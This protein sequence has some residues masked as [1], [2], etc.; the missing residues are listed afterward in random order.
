MHIE[1]LCVP[2]AVW[3]LRVLSW[4]SRSMAMSDMAMLNNY[5]DS[6]LVMIQFDF[7]PCFLGV[8]NGLRELEAEA[9]SAL[10]RA[11]LARAP[12]LFD[13]RRSSASEQR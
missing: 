9:M 5:S 12:E 11:L 10:Q 1:C 8:H 13:P 3:L 7:F 4:E 2:S 6:L